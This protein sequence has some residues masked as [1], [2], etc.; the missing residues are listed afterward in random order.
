MLSIT[1]SK[2]RDE[3]AAG[4]YRDL[5]VEKVFPALG[6]RFAYATKVEEV[7]SENLLFSN[8]KYFIRRYGP[9]ISTPTYFFILV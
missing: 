9:L 2:T 7:V 1:L 5:M 6:A 4:L 8:Y 3:V